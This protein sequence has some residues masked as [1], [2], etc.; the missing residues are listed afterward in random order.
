MN[1]WRT[2]GFMLSAGILGSSVST[3]LVFLYWNMEAP[4]PLHPVA[5]PMSFHSLALKPQVVDIPTKE[6]AYLGRFAFNTETINSKGKTVWETQW[7]HYDPNVRYKFIAP[8][9]LE[10]GKFSVMLNIDYVL[11]P[12]T[13]HADSV[14][15]LDFTIDEE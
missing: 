11:N 8:S 2:A 4:L 9:G 15:F 5:L 7:V 12:V 14:K 1:K 3:G 13:R 10:P 6:Y